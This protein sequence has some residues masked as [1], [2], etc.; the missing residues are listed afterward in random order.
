MRNLIRPLE[1]YVLFVFKRH[2]RHLLIFAAVFIAGFVLGLILGSGGIYN[3]II[4]NDSINFTVLIFSGKASFFAII[5]RGFLVNLQYFALIFIFSLSVYFIPLHYVFICY[6]GYVLGAAAVVFTKVLGVHGFCN[7]LI[8]VLPQ[9]LILLLCLCLFICSAHKDI[10]SC[11][12]FTFIGERAK[13]C[14]V[15]FFISLSNIIVQLALIYVIIKPF[16][17]LI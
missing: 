14:C 1:S 5:A 9:Q 17:I 8:L 6:K 4:F 3:D 12:S 16:N 13:C 11:K 10:I 2:K 15:Y 7:L